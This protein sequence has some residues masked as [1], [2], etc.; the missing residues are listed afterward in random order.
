MTDDKLTTRHHLIKFSLEYYAAGRSAALMGLH[1]VAP[2][3]LHHA[4]ELILKAVL[5][6]VSSLGELK[7]NHSHDL[8]SLW[9]A[10]VVEI[11]AL[12]T[13]TR[14]Q[15]IAD[16]DKFEA[17]RYPDSLVRQGA[18]VTIGIHSG[19]NPVTDG[20]RPTSGPTYRFN[21]EDID[22][23]WAG[24]F[25][26]IPANPEVFLQGLSKQARSALMA[27]NQHPIAL[28]SS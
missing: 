28:P 5:V 10:A 26:K 8:N 6:R 7:H 22:E 21:V 3:L 13:P 17:L 16:L 11:P 20:T 24:V 25:V 2:L 1:R 19:E 14:D 18:T 15:A 12:K 27:D 23:L 9:Q 4:I